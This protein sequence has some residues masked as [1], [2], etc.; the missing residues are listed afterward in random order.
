MAIKPTSEEEK[1][2]TV[3][4]GIT[5]TFE[6]YVNSE[7]EENFGEIIDRILQ[8]EGIVISTIEWLPDDVNMA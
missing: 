8:L 2:E 3:Y 4:T 6:V 7:H 5:A 1:K